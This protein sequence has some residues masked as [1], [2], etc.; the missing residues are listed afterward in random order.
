MMSESFLYRIER[1]EVTILRSTMLWHEAGALG[2][3]SSS[4]ILV[5]VQLDERS[6]DAKWAIF[7]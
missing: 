6:H 1:I 5:G 2:R 3:H 4:L 7:I